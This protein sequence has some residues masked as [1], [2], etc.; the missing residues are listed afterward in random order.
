MGVRRCLK[1]VVIPVTLLSWGAVQEM[2]KTA[3]RG[4]NAALKLQSCQSL[5]L[6]LE[7]GLRLLHPM[8]PFVTEELW[9]RL[10]CRGH[11]WSATVADPASICVAAW[12]AEIPQFDKPAID[13]Q[14]NIAVQAVKKGRSLK[15]TAS[16]KTG[17]PFVIVS[18]VRR[19]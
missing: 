17:V 8:M 5:L 7:I 19:V 11:K 14:F 13:A 4:T 10:P 9:Q 6:C 16:I 12:P 1:E 15:D 3:L 18:S 2:A